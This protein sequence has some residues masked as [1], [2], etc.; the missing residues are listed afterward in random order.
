MQISAC[1]VL[2]HGSG[3]D[4]FQYQ[5]DSGGNARQVIYS[6]RAAMAAKKVDGSVVTWGD[7]YYGGDSSAVSSQLASGASAPTEWVCLFYHAK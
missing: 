1:L 2:L 6:N 4:P 7:A 5:G 3:I